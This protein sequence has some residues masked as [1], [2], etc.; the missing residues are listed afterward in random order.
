MGG[1]NPGKPTRRPAGGPATDG[2]EEEKPF[3]S[4]EF[5][6]Q[7]LDNLLNAPERPTWDEFKERQRK[8]G[9]LEGGMEKMEEEAQ[10]RFRKELDEERAQRLAHGRNRTEEESSKKKKKDKHKSK[11]DKKEKKEKKEKSKKKKRRRDDS[12]D[13]DS[14]DDDDARRGKAHKAEAPVSLSSFFAAGDSD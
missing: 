5:E 11:K 1:K 9:E 3:H 7:H 2:T 6:Q 14:T 13:S 8:K 12:D 4:K 10:R